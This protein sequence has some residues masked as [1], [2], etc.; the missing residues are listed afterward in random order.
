M[1][2][3][4]GMIRMEAA[5]TTDRAMKNKHSIVTFKILDFI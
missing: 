4:R 2:S 3:P 1:E 5:L